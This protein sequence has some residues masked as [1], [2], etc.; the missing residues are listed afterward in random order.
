MK[1]S[2]R[3]GVAMIAAERRAVAVLAAVFSVRMLGLFLLL[4]IIALYAAR[5]PG[6]PAV[7]V[8]LAVGAYG[9]TQA[10]LQI[11]FGLLSD[12]F[13][14]KPVIVAGLLIFSLGSLVAAAAGSIEML[15]AGRILQ[16]AGAISAAVTALVADLTRPQVRTRAMAIIGMTIGASFLLSLVAGPLLADWL[17]FSGVFVMTAGLG[18]IAIAFVIFAV[19]T[20]GPVRKPPS[21]AGALRE[22]LSDPRLLQLNAGVLILHAALTASFVALPFT[23]AALSEVGVALHSRV[24]LFALLGSLPATVAL[25]IFNERIPAPRRWLGL[26]ILLLMLAQLS[27]ST[28][29]SLWPITVSLAIFF[30]GF[31]FL[32][33]RLP[34]RMSELASPGLRGAALGVFATCQF[35]G[36]FL[37]GLLG[38]WLYGLGGSRGVHL[39]LVGLTIIWLLF[40]NRASETAVAPTSRRDAT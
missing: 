26:A 9:L 22:A 3:S 37:G 31:N 5:Y 35:L 39:A 14:R 27:L 10:L 38:G 16:G 18:L 33:A 6:T 15:I 23:L 29:A 2:G 20:P 8:G 34:A 21:A 12:Y 24:Y 13:G 4:P 28:V 1:H 17:G 25:I 40:A 19:P 32:E 30:S 7:M 11:P 36:A